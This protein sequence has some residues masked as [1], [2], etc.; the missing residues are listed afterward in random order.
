MKKI[1]LSLVLLAAIT[2]VN[3]QVRVGVKAGLNLANITG[4]DANGFKTHANFHVGGLVN[5]P[6]SGG[7]SVQPELIYSGQ[8]AKEEFEGES[9]KVNLSYINIP[10]LA[11]Y[12]FNGGFYAETGPQLG[13]LVSAKEKIGGQSQDIKDQIKSSDFAWGIG[14]GYQSEAGFGGGVRYNYGLGKLD[15]N[16]NS[17]VYNSVI[18]IGVHYLFGASKK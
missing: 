1:I 7:F 3:A 2:V 10:V 18:Q 12:T 14:V 15:K 5:I 11:K 6:V 8:G 9:G 4:S 16:S 17:K 13:F